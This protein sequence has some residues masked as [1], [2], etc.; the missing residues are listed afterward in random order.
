MSYKLQVVKAMEMLSRDKRVL[1]LGQTVRYPGSLVYQ[2]LS[3]LSEA[4]KIE[5]P[6]MEDCQMGLSIGLSLEGFIPVSIYPRMDFLML[7]MNQLVN[8]LDKIEKISNGEFKS[9]VIIRTMVGSK[10]P[11]YPGVQHCSDYTGA[12]KLLLKNIKVVKL[13]KGKDIIP[14]YKEALAS[15]KSTLIIE[16]ADLYNQE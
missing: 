11:F 2:T 15:D 3:S 10:K 9:K 1:F 4:K 13:D 16:V 5:L 12:L 14:A 6:I 8:H 7:A